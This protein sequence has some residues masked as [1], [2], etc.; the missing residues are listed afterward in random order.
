MM[1]IDNYNCKL[2]LPYFNKSS[3]SVKPVER[4]VITVM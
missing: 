2:E 3:A 4:A 1:V